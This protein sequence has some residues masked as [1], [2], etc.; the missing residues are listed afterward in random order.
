M[1]RQIRC[2]GWCLSRR[3]SLRHSS[4]CIRKK[5]EESLSN[6]R[7]HIRAC[8]ATTWPSLLIMF[9]TWLHLKCLCLFQYFQI[10]IR[11]RV[12]ANRAKRVYLCNWWI[13][14]WPIVACHTSNWPGG[15]ELCREPPA[16]CCCS[17]VQFQCLPQLQSCSLPPLRF[18]QVNPSLTIFTFTFWCLCIL[19]YFCWSF[20][21][22]DKWTDDIFLGDNQIYSEIQVI[23]LFKCPNF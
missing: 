19:I 22:R 5:W 14:C 7:A 11:E 9:S 16:G 13:N 20:L 12:Q 18:V 15:D 21:Y 8:W 10:N 2:T 4:E 1:K 6:S 23:L 3:V 17:Q